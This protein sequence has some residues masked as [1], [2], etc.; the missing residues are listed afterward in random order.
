MATDDEIAAKNALVRLPKSNDY[1]G[2][3][4]PRHL[5]W[6]DPATIQAIADIA[7][8]MCQHYPGYKLEIG[9]IT[10]KNRQN[11]YSVSHQGQNFDMAYPYADGQSGILDPEGKTNAPYR[12]NAAEV[13]YDMLHALLTIISAHPQNSHVLVGNLV[14]P[15]L[16]SHIKT[17]HLPALPNVA[18][19]AGHDDHIH[20]SMKRG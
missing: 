8:Q 11:T 1:V 10:G 3:F 17:K 19:H 4:E 5:Y 12:Q 7:A 16:Q 6:G 15:R 13:D 2:Y 9:N 14:H 18:A 20:V